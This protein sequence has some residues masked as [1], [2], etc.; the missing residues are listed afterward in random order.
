MKIFITGV[1]GLIG[2]H[3]ADFLINKKKA[4][5]NEAQSKGKQINDFKNATEIFFK[6]K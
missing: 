4:A 2:S 3:L 6:N 5:D 1:T